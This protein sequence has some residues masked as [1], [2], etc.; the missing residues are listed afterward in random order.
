[1]DL[2]ALTNLFSFKLY[3]NAEEMQHFLRCFSRADLLV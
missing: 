3:L 2:A 1:M